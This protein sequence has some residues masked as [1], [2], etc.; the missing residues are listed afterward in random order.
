MLEHARTLLLFPAFR[1]SKERNAITKQ[2]G[3]TFHKWEFVKPYFTLQIKCN[4]LPCII[5][6]GLAFVTNQTAWT[7]VDNSA[8]Y[9]DFNCG[10]TS[11][12]HRH[13]LVGGASPDQHGGRAE[14]SL[15]WTVRYRC[16]YNYG[17]EGGQHSTA[18]AIR[19]QLDC[20]FTS[21]HSS[22][23]SPVSNSET[24]DRPGSSPPRPLCPL[25]PPG[26]SGSKSASFSRSSVKLQKGP[27]VDAT[28]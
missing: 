18:L 7:S 17:G 19:E 2:L 23:C 3:I 27:S 21:T 8:S 22:C 16:V 12:L 15:R 11:C 13:A 10:Q 9:D 20:R 6:T 26:S 28:R 25:C 5:N 14:A 1:C 24:A 4:R